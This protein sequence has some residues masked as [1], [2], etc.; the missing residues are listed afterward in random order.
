MSNGK[1]YRIKSNFRTRI[2]FTIPFWYHIN[3]REVR[4]AK[5]LIYSF[6]RFIGDQAYVREIE[7]QEKL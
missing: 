2:Q 6:S 4:F 5:S 1:M 3:A 7:I